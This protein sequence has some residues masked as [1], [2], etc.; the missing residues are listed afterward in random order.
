MRFF[1]LLVLKSLINFPPYPS[2]S[3]SLLCNNIFF[4]GVKFYEIFCRI[5]ISSLSHFFFLTKNNK[6]KNSGMKNEIIST[7]PLSFTLFLLVCVSVCLCVCVSMSLLSLLGVRFW[8][9]LQTRY[10]STE[11]KE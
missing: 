9:V 8:D 1:I 6:A 7:V 5:F 11:R 10:S 2:T 3:L 4:T